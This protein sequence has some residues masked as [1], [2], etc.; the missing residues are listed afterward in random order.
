[1][2]TSD[3]NNGYEVAPATKLAYGVGA[4]SDSIKTLSFTMFL[5]FYYTTVLGLS[6]TLLALAMAVGLVWD[7]AVD[8]LIGHMS[9]RAQASFGRRHS[10]MLVGAVRGRKLH[11]G[12]QSPFGAL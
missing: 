6:G 7:A 11:R 9:D 5:L 2:I 10:F 1:M 12:L 4:L 3:R 8:P